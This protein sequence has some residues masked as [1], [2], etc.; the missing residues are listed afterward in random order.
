MDYAQFNDAELNAQLYLDGP[1][2]EMYADDDEA[3]RGEAP[4]RADAVG[5]GLLS[6]QRVFF[7]GTGCLRVSQWIFALVAFAAMSETHGYSHYSAFSF[8]IF[9]G[10]VAWLHVSLVVWGDLHDWHHRHRAWFP[11]Y[12]FAAD[13][14]LTVFAFAAAVSVAV[15][16]GDHIHS[17]PTAHA[18]SVCAADHHPKVSAAFGVFLF[19]FLAVSTLVS[20]RRRRRVALYYDQQH[21]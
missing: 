14:I 16:C 10:V 11:T 5:L 15:K 7:N 19:L 1:Q 9:A 18:E 2:S 4:C 3:L 12:Q 6:V 17:T 13:L 21:H 8:M 20:Y